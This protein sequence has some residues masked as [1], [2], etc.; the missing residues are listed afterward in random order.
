MEKEFEVPGVVNPDNPSELMLLNADKAKNATENLIDIIV[1]TT[2][3]KG[4]QVIFLDKGALA[5][6]KKIASDQYQRRT[7]KYRR[8]GKRNRQRV[9]ADLIL[10]H[11][12]YIPPI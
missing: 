7:S 5:E 12:H 10:I 11:T 6:H 3:L 8:A 4:G 9:D 1:E 2:L